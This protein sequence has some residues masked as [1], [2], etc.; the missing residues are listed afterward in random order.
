MYFVH[1]QKRLIA[2]FVDNDTYNS[3]R[4]I[5]K[6]WYSVIEKL[7]D[8]EYFLQYN[9]NDILED[10]VKKIPLRIEK[11]KL[12]SYNFNKNI[13]NLLSRFKYLKKVSFYQCAFIE[14]NYKI[15]KYIETVSFSY[16]KFSNHNNLYENLDLN[17][18]PNRLKKLKIKSNLIR[19]H[20]V[21]YPKKLKKLIIESNNFN[22]ELGRLP[23]LIELEIYSKNFNKQV[24]NL[25]KSLKY[26]TLWSGTFNQPLNYLP[27]INNLSINCPRLY[28]KINKLPNSLEKLEIINNQHNIIE[29]L[30]NNLKSLCLCK[31]TFEDFDL[32]FLPNNLEVLEIFGLYFY[33]K[34]RGIPKSIKQIFFQQCNFNNNV[35]DNLPNKLKF[36]DINNCQ[37]LNKIILPSKKTKLIS[38]IDVIVYIDEKRSIYDHVSGLFN[39]LLTG[40]KRKR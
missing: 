24:Y 40:F 3:L 36:L 5:N 12:G 10:E 2:S 20:I 15:P 38:N 32:N 31:T 22:L 1:A 14:K 35:L 13:N 6:D 23:K 18:L 11:L 37:R 27:K 16:C 19:N 34:L 7:P 21:N 30:P 8:N 26:L 33:K 9:I 29:K 4:S 25:P 17:I 39:N 28:I